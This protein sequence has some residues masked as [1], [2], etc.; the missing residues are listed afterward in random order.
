[1]TKVKESKDFRSQ[2]SDV[3][4]EEEVEIDPEPLVVLIVKGEPM[5]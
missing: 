3:S 5:T 1:M 4:K 2:I